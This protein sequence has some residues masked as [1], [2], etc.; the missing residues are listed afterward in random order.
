MATTGLSLRLLTVNPAVNRIIL[1]D[2]SPK[3][4]FAM[5]GICNELDVCYYHNGQRISYVRAYNF[6][7]Q[8]L[9]EPYIGLMT[10]D[11]IPHPL[12]TIQTLLEWIKH[13]NRW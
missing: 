10:N 2:G 4:D 9:D 1:V 3:P 12:E 8:S 13:P 11:I 5:K 7:W 6:G